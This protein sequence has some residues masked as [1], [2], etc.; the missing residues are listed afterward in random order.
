MTEVLAAGQTA[1][2]VFTPRMAA[3]FFVLGIF[4]GAVWKPAALIAGV[5]VGIYV[6]VHVGRRPLPHTVLGT[7]LII[8]I[9]ALVLGIIIGGPLALRSLSD[10]DYRQRLLNIRRVSSIWR[11]WGGKDARPSD[12]PNPPNWP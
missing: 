3:L 6:L 2:T 12:T 5:L 11:F 10:F 1:T 8:A 4:L 9:F 7:V